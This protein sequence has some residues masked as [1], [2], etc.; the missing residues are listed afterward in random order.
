[1][2]GLE[3]ALEGVQDDVF[4]ALLQSVRHGLEQLLPSMIRRAQEIR[5]EVEEERYYEEATIDKRLREEFDQLSQKYRDGRLLEDACWKWA[6]KAGLKMEADWD[7]PQIIR[8]DPRRF[9][10]N[11]LKNA[12]FLHFP[13]M[14]EALAHSRHKRD[15]VI[16]GTFDRDL[17]V[18]REDLVF[19]APGNDAW[20]DTIIE[21]AICADRG[22]CC[23]IHRR[24]P[25]LKES[26]RGFELFYSLTIDPR[27]LY[28]HG[29]DPTHLFQA[30]G[31]LKTS[32]YRLI[33]SHKGK[34][35]SKDSTIGK[36]LQGPGAKMQI[37]ISESE[38][39]NRE[40][41]AIS[42]N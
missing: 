24:V 9:N 30:L 37:F 27:P 35:E 20:I 15:L 23:A 32:S 41:T 26:W 40:R 7:N 31:F 8:F 22:R 28:Q 21:N 29:F 6:H 17:A 42:G 34:L 5:E 16:K 36:I 19:F 2:S 39:R 18:R 4:N 25:G 1:M 11:S 38:A 12:K 13:D 14:Q 33:V 3:I 10:I